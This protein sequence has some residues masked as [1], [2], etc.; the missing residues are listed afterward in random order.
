[1]VVP[2]QQDTI[3]LFV[4]Q[5]DTDFPVDAVS[6]SIEVNI[7]DVQQATVSASKIV[8]IETE[9]LPDVL[10]SGFRLMDVTILADIFTSCLPSMFFNQFP[11]IA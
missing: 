3:L 8:N 11:T 9:T 1:M 6:D 4:R 5:N 10:L 7:E 2:P